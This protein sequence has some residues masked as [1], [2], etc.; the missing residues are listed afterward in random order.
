M[1]DIQHVAG[2]VH[3]L[4]RFR[5]GGD[6]RFAQ[7]PFGAVGDVQRQFGDDAV[8]R[9]GGGAHFRQ[10]AQLADQ[11]RISAGEVQQEQVVLGQVAAKARSGKVPAASCC[12]NG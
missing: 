1:A 6:L 3:G 12:R 10:G 11:Q 8:E 9:G 7:P 4:R 2:V 5:L